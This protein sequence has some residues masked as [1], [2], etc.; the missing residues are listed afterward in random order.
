MI[1]YLIYA[2]ECIIAVT[3]IVIFIKKRKTTPLI[4]CS[5]PTIVSLIFFYLFAKWNI[6]PSTTCLES[7]GC[8]N[9]TGMLL[10]FAWFFMFIS[11]MILLLASIVYSLIERRNGFIL[12]S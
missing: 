1:S 7:E 11:I 12:K 9:E 10:V 8:M 3:L 2:I 5:I 4:L 6:F